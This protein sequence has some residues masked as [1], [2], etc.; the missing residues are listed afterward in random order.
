[1]NMTRTEVIAKLQQA[2]ATLAE[3]MGYTVMVT[4]ENR[5]KGIW[6]EK[7]T[8]FLEKKSGECIEDI[9]WFREDKPEDLKYGDNIC[10]DF[11]FSTPRL[12][13]DHRNVDGSFASIDISDWNHKAYK[14]Y[15]EELEALG[16]NPS[17]IEKKEL[18]KKHEPLYRDGNFKIKDIQIFNGDDDRGME[19]LQLLQNAWENN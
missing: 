8:E 3:K 19:F 15:Q 5:F 7:F 4:G 10:F 13:I 2:G 6:G 1:M 17:W 9:K 18:E 12:A 14:K 16:E 11:R